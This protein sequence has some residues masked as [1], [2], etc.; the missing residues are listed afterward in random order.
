MRPYSQQKFDPIGFII[1]MLMFLF[2][3]V[4]SFILNYVSVHSTPYHL[5]QFIWISLISLYWLY[6][7]IKKL[8]QRREQQEQAHWYTQP[9][10]LAAIG[11]FYLAPFNLVMAFLGDTALDAVPTPIEIALF[12]PTCICFLAAAF[13]FF[14]RLI[15]RV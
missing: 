6:S 3:V 12:A 8:R 14:R 5:V 9:G 2:F 1:G 4:Q 13:Y 7:G 10:I 15:W 11:G